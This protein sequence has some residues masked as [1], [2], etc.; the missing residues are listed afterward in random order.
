MLDYSQKVTIACTG[1][2]FS[3][4]LSSAAIY[5]NP[6]Q[7]LLSKIQLQPLSKLTLYSWTV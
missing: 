3:I 1:L 5:C 2:S 7:G 4:S 6:F